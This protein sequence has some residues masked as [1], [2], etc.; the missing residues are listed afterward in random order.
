MS[1]GQALTHWD[2]DPSPTPACPPPAAG[3]RPLSLPVLLRGLARGRPP[4]PRALQQRESHQWGTPSRGTCPPPHP[5]QGQPKWGV[6]SGQH[7]TPG[8]HRAK[9]A[10]NQHPGAPTALR[11]PPLPEPAGHNEAFIGAQSHP[12][13]CSTL[14]PRFDVSLCCTPPHATLRG[15][16]RVQRGPVVVTKSGFFHAK[17]PPLPGPDNVSVVEGTEA[18]AGGG[19]G[20]ALQDPRRGAGGDR[21][22][23]KCPS[24]AAG[25]RQP[26]HGAAGVTVRSALKAAR[27]PVS[28]VAGCHRLP[29]CH[30]GVANPVA[31]RPQR[32]RGHLSANP[33]ELDAFTI[34]KVAARHVGPPRHLSDR[35]VTWDTPA[36]SGTSPVVALAG[37]REPGHRT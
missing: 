29:L 17:F 16:P 20:W 12:H 3:P 18:W 19:T 35:E 32:I 1:Q 21:A 23:P 6:P 10:P 2:T 27:W 34:G 13:I 22:V 4:E 15:G 37:E 26:R 24:V 33:S 11:A 5:I 25:F 8:E 31:G 7:Q 36:P 14:T 9:P 28:V 30:T